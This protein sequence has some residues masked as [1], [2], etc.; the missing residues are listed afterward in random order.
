MKVLPF[1]PI[2][3]KS[4]FL[5]LTSQNT[6]SSGGGDNAEKG[7]FEVVPPQLDLRM[8]TIKPLEQKERQS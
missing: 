8:D 2:P 4:I 6:P 7:L 5:H 1:S 3:E